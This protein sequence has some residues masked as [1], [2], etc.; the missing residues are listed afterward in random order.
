MSYNFLIEALQELVSGEAFT[1]D[2]EFDLEN[3][4]WI[5]TPDPMPSD[6]AIIS[7]CNSLQSTYDGLLYSRNRKSEYDALNQFEL[8]SDDAAGSTTTHVDA[9][10]AIKTKW[11]KNNK[12]PIE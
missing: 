1:I 9:I 8:I 7:K 4:T 2:G 12:G 5:E 3:V 6:S 11:P 10:A